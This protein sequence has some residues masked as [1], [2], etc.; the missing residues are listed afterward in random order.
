MKRINKTLAVTLSVVLIITS[1]PPRE[2]EASWFSDF[3]GGLFT[4]ITAPIW[5]FCQDN[6]TFRKNNPFRKKVWEVEKEAQKNYYKQLPRPP[7]KS[8]NTIH[9]KSEDPVLSETVSTKHKNYALVDPNPENTVEEVLYRDPDVAA[10]EF[11]LYNGVIV[12]KEPRIISIKTDSYCP[13]VNPAYAEYDIDGYD[14]DG[15]NRRGVDKDGYG[16]DG[17]NKDGYNR[18]GFRKNADL[19][20]QT[21]QRS[22]ATTPS[23]TISATPE[24]IPTKIA[25]PTNAPSS[26]ISATPETTP[27]KI[28]DVNKTTDDFSISQWI[29]KQAKKLNI[30]QKFAFID[31]GLVQVKKNLRN[32]KNLPTL[33]IQPSL[34]ILRLEKPHLKDKEED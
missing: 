10:F 4:I 5:V 28:D 9:N 23:P 14:K 18:Q 25:T 13:T 26:T 19:P 12:E 33:K 6:P 17:F 16:K 32:G 22:P 21:S 3:C 34:E 31:I 24:A 1:I 8:D 20:T 7:K 11:K 27:M 30:Y 15:F 2:V 29:K